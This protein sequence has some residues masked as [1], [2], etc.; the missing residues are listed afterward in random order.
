MSGME[1]RRG[2]GGGLGGRAP[3]NRKKERGGGGAGSTYNKKFNDTVNI[4]VE[5]TNKLTFLMFTFA[6]IKWHV[7]LIKISLYNR[8]TEMVAYLM[9]T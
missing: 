6:S 4:L 3:Q 2:E 1:L 8:L 7:F 9:S 5:L